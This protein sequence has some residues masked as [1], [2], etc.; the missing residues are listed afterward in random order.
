MIDR[1]DVDPASVRE[2]LLTLEHANRRFGV[3]Q[4]TLDSLQRFLARLAVVELRI[5]DFGTGHADIPRALI[6][7]ARQRR[8]PITVT[9][10][11]GNPTVLR[12]ARESCRDWPEIQLVQQ[13]LRSLPYPA[14]SFDVVLCSLALHHFT[15]EDAVGILGR[16]QEMARIGY[17]LNDLRRNYSAILLTRLLLPVFS[18]SLIVRQDGS[19][20]SRAAFTVGELRSMASR[21]GLRNFIIRR[22][23]GVFRM[24][25]EGRK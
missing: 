11:D 21:A 20:S 5:L 16:M 4:M 7:W 9:A 10:V 12:S 14:E 8:L 2:E 1:P 3:Y 24:A 25:L 15:E 6:A 13:D 23:Q 19:Q 17:I 18:K 22:H